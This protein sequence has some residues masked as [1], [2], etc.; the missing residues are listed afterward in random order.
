M[1]LPAKL[2][3]RLFYPAPTVQSL[4]PG[5]ML[6]VAAFWQGNH[7]QTEVTDGTEVTETTGIETKHVNLVMRQWRAAFH[8]AIIGTFD[9]SEIMVGQD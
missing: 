2:T 9:D 4:V 3:D 5:V 8:A 1:T 7:I 6:Q